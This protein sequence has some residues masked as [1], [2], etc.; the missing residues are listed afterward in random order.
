ML[1][2]WQIHPV[3]SGFFCQFFW[4]DECDVIHKTMN[5]N[6]MACH[7]WIY[8]NTNAAID[9]ILSTSDPF[10]HIYMQHPYTVS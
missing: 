4:C 6:W 10:V 9:E 7:T 5:Q 8:R 3:F 2:D 1:F